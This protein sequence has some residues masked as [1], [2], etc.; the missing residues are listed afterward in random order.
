MV[1]ERWDGVEAALDPQEDY[2]S[3]G[4]YLEHFQAELLSGKHGDGSYE[5]DFIEEHTAT[6]ALAYALH[7]KAGFSTDQV[8]VIHRSSSGVAPIMSILQRI[9]HSEGTYKEMNVPLGQRIKVSGRKADPD[10]H[11]RHDDTPNTPNFDG[12][13]ENMWKFDDYRDETLSFLDTS[14]VRRLESTPWREVNRLNDDLVPGRQRGD[15]TSEIFYTA[16]AAE[17]IDVVLDRDDIAENPVEYGND[18]WKLVEGAGL[19]HKNEV[20]EGDADQMQID[21][22]EDSGDF[23]YIAIDE[24]RADELSVNYGA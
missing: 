14:Q 7:E 23:E 24:A 11:L 5:H 10:N 15:E 8:R 6:G 19:F 18:A 2:E 22:N 21:Y 17:R 4:H 12:F 3:F 16:S 9:D 13:L 20:L 1:D